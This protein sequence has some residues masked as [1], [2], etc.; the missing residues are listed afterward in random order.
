VRKFARG[1]FL[2]KARRDKGGGVDV[3]W[4]LM[5]VLQPG[6]TM[7]LNRKETV[8]HINKITRPSVGA[9]LSAYGSCSGHPHNL[10]MVINRLR[11][12]AA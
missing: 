12:Q 10:F 2:G 5:V 1:D 9:D 3:G 8:K 7:Q 11:K 4:A 6:A